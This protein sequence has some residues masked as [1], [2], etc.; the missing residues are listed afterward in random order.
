MQ[1]EAECEDRRA[2]RQ[3]GHMMKMQ[4]RF[5]QQMQEMIQVHKHMGK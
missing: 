1:A 2:S 4:Q 5:M 3:E